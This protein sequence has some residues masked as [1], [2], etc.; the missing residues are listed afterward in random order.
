MSDFLEVLKHSIQITGF[1]FVM[2]LLVEYLNV[3]SL[4]T[5][6]QF[7]S[8]RP[9]SQ[10]LLAA[11]LGATPGC[12]GAFG[13]VALY[14]HGSI[15]LGALVA[16]ML[17]TAGD[18]SFVMFAMFPRQAILIHIL[19]L[20]IGIACGALTDLIV[21]RRFRLNLMP[22][23]G[24]TLHETHLEDVS[25]S[26][27]EIVRQL[28]E[29]SLSRGV[30]LISLSLLLLGCLTGA[31]GPQEW[32][33]IRVT[34]VLGTAVALAIVL[35]VSDHFLEEHL[36]RHVAV[37]HTPRI[38]L[39]TLGAMLLVHFLAHHLDL[40]DVVRSNKWLVLAIAS[41][42]GVIPESGPHLVFVTLYSRDALPLSILLANSIV[43]DGHG[44]LPLLAFSRRAFLAVKGINLLI[45][46]AVG[47]IGLLLGR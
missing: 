9:W 30:L 1:V 38:F 23:K 37:Q 24:L 6:R 44:A 39:W 19:L 28:R 10:Y 33:W 21:G 18:E 13:A 42:T 29:C 26:G 35:S 11:F 4:G 22:C 7:L 34:V 16:A 8:A 2:M 41:V 40:G 43:Q 3:R 36:W 45:A 14:G 25:L 17:A 46:L 27:S 5:W 31:V 47:A 12:L 20:G 32:N 15:S